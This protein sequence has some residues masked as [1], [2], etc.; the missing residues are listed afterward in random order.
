MQMQKKNCN[1][2]SPINKTMRLA[3]DTQIDLTNYNS[4]ESF[5]IIIISIYA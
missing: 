5:I 3:K 2:N 1:K 4:V